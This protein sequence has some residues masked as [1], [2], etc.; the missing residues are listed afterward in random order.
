[1]LKIQKNSMIHKKLDLED[2]KD[3]NKNPVIVQNLIGLINF[4]AKQFIDPDMSFV[5]DQTQIDFL[6]NNPSLISQNDKIMN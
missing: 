2:P 6:S 5:G 1:M 4:Y 3:Y